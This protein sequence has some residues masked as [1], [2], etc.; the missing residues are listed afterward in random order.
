VT[1][2]GPSATVQLGDAPPQLPFQ[3]LKLASAAGAPVSVTALTVNVPEHTEEQLIPAGVLTTLPTPEPLTVT[4]SVNIWLVMVKV[5]APDVPP[6]GNG[7]NT[8]IWVVPAVVM[9]PAEMAARNSV[10]LTNVVVRSEPFQRTTDG[11]A[12]LAPLTV[13]VN[14]AP[15]AVALLGESETAV[16]AGGLIVN[17]RALDVSPIGKKSNTVTCADPVRAT[18]LAGMAARNSVPLTNVV[19]RFESFQRTTEE[20]TKFVPLTVSVNAAP[21]AVALLGESAPS[22][23]TGTGL[24]PVPV[25]P[26]DTVPPLYVKLTFPVTIAT[27][28]G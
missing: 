3:L 4:V 21:P 13:S 24:V 20:A 11:A 14:P 25:S 28:V 1:A 2:V 10:L 16:G 23:G 27:A 22:T 26:R 9:S 6:P 12:K 15:P 7:V 19:V 18:S 8:V 5:R 17:V